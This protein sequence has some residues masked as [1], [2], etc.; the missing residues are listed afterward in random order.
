MMSVIG[1]RRAGDRD[2]SRTLIELVLRT[3]WKVN[4]AVVPRVATQNPPNRFA[5]TYKRAVFFNAKYCVL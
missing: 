3:S 5:D 4:S 1:V 2:V